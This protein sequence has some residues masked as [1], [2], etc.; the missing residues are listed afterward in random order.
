MGLV[1]EDL[2]EIISTVGF[3]IGVCVYLLYERTKSTDKSMTELKDA[4]RDLHVL[5]AE[6]VR[7][8]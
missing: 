4:I 5:I 3:P 1:M 8:E 7:K 6:R 2:I